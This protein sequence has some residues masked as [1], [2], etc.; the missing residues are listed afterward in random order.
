MIQSMAKVGFAF[1]VMTLWLAPA[2]HSQSSDEQ[3]RKDIEALKQSQQ[4][5]LKE[6]GEI[7]QLLQQRPAAPPKPNVKGV[8]LD[9]GDNPIVGQDT[10][11]LTLVEFTDY[12]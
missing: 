7:K 2:A 10:A 1:A 12:Q 9:L 5:I 4:Q 6:L 11:K 3:L 8:V